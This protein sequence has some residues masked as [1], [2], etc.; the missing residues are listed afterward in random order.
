MSEAVLR[1]TGVRWKHRDG[2]RL[3]LFHPTA[4]ASSRLAFGHDL[5]R[6]RPFLGQRQGRHIVRLAGTKQR[7]MI[8]YDEF[9]RHRQI[10]HTLEL[11]VA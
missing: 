9:R 7:Q 1:R 3:L 6:P 10:R 5:L 8:E 4:K 2:I 11:G